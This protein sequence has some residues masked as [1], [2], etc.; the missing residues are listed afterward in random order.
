MPEHLSSPVS[1]IPP[2][3]LAISCFLSAVGRAICCR[4]RKMMSM[5]AC[6][7]RA[8]LIGVTHV[9]VLD[10]C[11]ASDTCLGSYEWGRGSYVW[12]LVRE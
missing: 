8:G 1:I 7:H 5:L 9:L 3:L 12:E 11:T 2:L 6:F 4:T 10:I